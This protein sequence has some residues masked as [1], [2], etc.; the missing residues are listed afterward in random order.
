MRSATD[1]R[2]AVQRDGRQPAIG[3]AVWLLDYGYRVAFSKDEA[4]EIIVDEDR[5]LIRDLE[6][7]LG[8]LQHIIEITRPAVV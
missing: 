7:L 4:N 8:V 6:K 3:Y 2:P 1:R 5:Y